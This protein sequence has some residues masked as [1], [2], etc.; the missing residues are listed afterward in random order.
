MLKIL[1]I[2]KNILE[3]LNIEKNCLVNSIMSWKWK[4]FIR[5][6]QHNGLE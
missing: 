2:K 5:N 4:H 1:R 6:E 3:A